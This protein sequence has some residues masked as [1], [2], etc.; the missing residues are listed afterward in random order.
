MQGLGDAFPA[1]SGFVLTSVKENSLV[2]VM[3]TSPLPTESQ[4]ATILA[5]WT[6]GLGKAVAFT[7]DAGQRWATDWTGWGEYDRFFSQMVRWSM[8]P[9]GDTGKFTVAT[10]VQGGKTR[11]IVSALDK[12]DEFL[13]YQSMDRHGAGAGHAIDPAHDGANGAGPLR[14]RV[15]LGP[16]RQLFDFGT[17]RA[18]R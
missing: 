6:Y 15:R 10:E 4:N 2:D 3:L 1:V 17:G 12:D 8:R 9:T 16:G 7:T 14:G 11:V 5:A 13:N 18:M